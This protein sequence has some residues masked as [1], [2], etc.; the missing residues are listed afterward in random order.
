[1]Q[2]CRYSA[3]RAHSALLLVFLLLFTTL[4]SSAQADIA[5]QWIESQ[6]LTDGSL[7]TALEPASPYQATAE[8]LLALDGQSS[9]S[10]P[11]TNYL[12]A[13]PLI[14]T[15]SLTR[16]LAITVKAGDATDTLVGELLALQNADGGFGE[17]RGYQ[18]TALDTALALDALAIAGHRGIA[19]STRAL[20][21]LLSAQSMDG[22]YH[23]AAGEPGAAYVTAVVLRALNHYR[24][25]Y[26]INETLSRTIAFLDGERQ[27]DGTWRD[28]WETATAL[29]ALTPAGADP[30]LLTQAADA[31]RADQQAN[32]SWDDSVYVTA[33]AM[34]ALAALE[35]M[36]PPPPVNE[37]AV[38]GRVLDA[39]NG[40]PVIGATLRTSTGLETT[41]AMDGSFALAGLSAGSHVIDI[42]AT[43]YNPLSLT[44]SVNAAGTAVL[45]NVLL[46]PM[47]DTGFIR[48]IVSRAADGAPIQGAS[49]TVS[50]TSVTTTQSDQEGRFALGATPG[51]VSVTVSAS[52]Y[53][54]VTASGTLTAGGSLWFTPMMREAGAPTR[55]L[56]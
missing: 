13:Q 35:D 30:Q 19:P 43:G 16:R 29:L 15:E 42:S 27:V 18:S 39:N 44:V 5:S 55:I 34:R 53:E 49:V 56:K 3:A 48:G 41:A 38:S 9:V 52:G 45:G 28:N 1:V 25:V 17:T 7:A 8:A 31:L 21:Y 20:E 50:G 14:T 47:P 37:G 51:A 22:G 11:A 23:P 54:P 12:A 33:L 24:A 40:Q 4:L 2:A 10:I 6:A 36:P 46:T 26:N 32:G